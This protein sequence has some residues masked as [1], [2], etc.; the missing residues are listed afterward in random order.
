MKL[1]TLAFCALLTGC[2]GSFQSPETTVYT[3]RSGYVVA[4]Q[5]A[6]AYESQPRCPAEPACSKAEVVDLLRK[7]DL[8]AKAALDAAETTVRNHPEIDA[9]FAIEA[10]RNAVSA[11]QAILPLYVE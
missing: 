6:V 5:G 2:A 1:I 11:F 3:I 9:D 8:T 7:S 10:A 4:L